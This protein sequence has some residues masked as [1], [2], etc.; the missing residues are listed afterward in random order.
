MHAISHVSKQTLSLIKD[1]TI[2]TV[3]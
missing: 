2:S 3:L 1:N